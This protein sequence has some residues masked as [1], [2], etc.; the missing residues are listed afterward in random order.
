MQINSWLIFKSKNNIWYWAARKFPFHRAITARVESLT[1]QINI[2]SVLSQSHF[3]D[4]LRG[5]A[6]SEKRWARFGPYYAIFPVK[7]AYAAVDAFTR[8][9]EAV[10]DPFVGR[11]SSIFAAGALGRRGLGVEINPVGALYAQAKL[12]PEPEYDL[13]ARLK[14]LSEEAAIYPAPL[15]SLPEFFRLCFAPRVLRFLLC[16]RARLRWRQDKTDAMLAAFILAHLHGRRG[17]ALSNQMRADRAMG[18]EYSVN[19]WRDRGLA[20]PPDYNPERFLAKKIAWRYRKGAPSFGGC[21]VVNAE[22][23]DLLRQASP[24]VSARGGF[25]LLLTSPPYFGVTDYHAEQWLRLWALGGPPSP[26]ALP[27]HNRARFT[28]RKRYAALL[29]DVFAAAAPLMTRQATVC[30]RTSR[31]EFTRETTRAALARHFP[32]YAPFCTGSDAETSG[33]V[34]FVLRRG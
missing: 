15:E 6:T 21:R 22:S 13:L 7:F 33:E 25:S 11:G 9:G 17:E 3:S 4:R 16:A 20:E 30:V 12:G 1:P 23:A 14:V 2:L 24:S 10:L 34:D 8:P 28:S 27:D 19:W 32:D 26:K 31:S 18:P 29:D 5:Y